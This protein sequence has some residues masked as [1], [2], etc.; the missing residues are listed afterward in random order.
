MIRFGGY[1]VAGF[2]LGDAPVGSW[3][4]VYDALVRSPPRTVLRYRSATLPPL[5]GSTYR[6]PP[7]AKCRGMHARAEGDKVAVHLDGVHPKCSIVWHLRKDTPSMLYAACIGGLVGYGVG[8][9]PGAAI[10]VGL[11]GGVAYAAIRR[12]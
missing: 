7:D 12:R 8:G 9:V 6:F 11:G 1:P 3:S 10:G 2:G 4:D 5:P